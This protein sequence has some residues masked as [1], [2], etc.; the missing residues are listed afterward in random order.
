LED[1]AKARANK[2]DKFH[3]MDLYIY[4]YFG[5][6]SVGGCA[7]P[8]FLESAAAIQK[9][10]KDTECTNRED[11]RKRNNKETLEKMQAK[12][13]KKLL[14]DS[15]DEMQECGPTTS[16]GEAYS[17][18]LELEEVRVETEREREQRE[19]TQYLISMLQ[20]LITQAATPQEKSEYEAEVVLL[21]FVSINC[22]LTTALIAWSTQYKLKT[23][24]LLFLEILHNAH[25]RLVRERVCFRNALHPWIRA[26]THGH[27]IANV[28]HMCKVVCDV[29][30]VYMMPSSSKFTATM[31]A[32]KGEPFARTITSLPGSVS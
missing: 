31:L 4:F 13:S 16:F 1:I 29:T 14:K 9:T 26:I 10:V 5:P 17:K 21:N 11:L 12:K 2:L 15:V 19:N 3:P 30:H 32:L 6:A 23:A 28:H 7:S 8:Y 22:L 20:G 18:Q 25:P 27:K 24:L